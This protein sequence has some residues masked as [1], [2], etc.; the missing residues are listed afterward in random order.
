MIAYEIY[1]FLCFNV[2][3]NLTTIT[4]KEHSESSV[5]QLRIIK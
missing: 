3:G 1:E 5:S 4:R 2:D